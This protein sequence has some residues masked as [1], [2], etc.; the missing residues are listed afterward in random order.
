MFCFPDR[1]GILV[2]IY[3]ICV[4]LA[5]VVA[6]ICDIRFNFFPIVMGFEEME[7]RLVGCLMHLPWVFT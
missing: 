6:Y 5:A 4:I 3:V 1:R 7:G 2:G